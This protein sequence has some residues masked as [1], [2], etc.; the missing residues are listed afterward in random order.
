MD[1]KNLMVRV[2]P[3]SEAHLIVEME[4][5]PDK[6]ILFNLEISLGLDNA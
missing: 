5:N 6:R 3:H 1:T 4:R 2:L